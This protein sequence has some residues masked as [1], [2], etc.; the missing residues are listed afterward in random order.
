MHEA[1]SG[2]VRKESPRY[3]LTTVAQR[4]YYSIPPT[5]YG[6]SGR[7]T[8]KQ[9][10]KKE[11]SG[12]RG[13][14]GMFVSLRGDL[15]FYKLWRDRLTVVLLGL[16]AFKTVVV[17]YTSLLRSTGRVRE[18]SVGFPPTLTAKL[19]IAAICQTQGALRVHVH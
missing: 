3:M 6:P 13:F 12:P 14:S 18:Q 16:L 19:S 15:T 5:Q 10:P 2:R 7:T 4:C 17:N 1:S 11:L 8:K 9:L